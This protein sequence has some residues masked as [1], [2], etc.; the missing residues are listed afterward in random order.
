MSN[1]TAEGKKKAESNGKDTSGVARTCLVAYLEFQHP[2]N[3]YETNLKRDAI[4]T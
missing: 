3:R 1:N 4:I 2:S